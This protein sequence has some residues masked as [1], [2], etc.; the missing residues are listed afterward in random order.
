MPL[1]ELDGVSLFYETAGDGPPVLIVRGTGGDLRQA[2]G[3]FAWPGSD[4]F[5][6]LAYDHRDQGR[7]SSRDAEQPTMAEF[8]SDA[9]ALVDHVG[10]DRFSVVGISFGGMV[11]QELALAAG[12]RVRR[13]V[14]A[15]TSSGGAGSR[16]YPLH[17]LYA[18][19]PEERAARL[20]AL[21][22]TRTASQPELAAALA[23]YLANDRSLAA[24]DVPTAG[25]LRQL[26]ARRHHDT[27][28]RL[29]GLRLPTLVA[30][31][32]FD[33]IAPVAA[34]ERL[35][36]SIP[37][38]RLAVFGGGHGFLLQDPAAWPAIAGF[39]LLPL[40]SAVE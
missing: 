34:S 6:L 5:S 4:R 35:A 37:G 20:V 8:T 32:R 22:D 2:P 30:A 9:L 28:E 3:P 12:D 17:E 10:W 26:Q 15:C 1:A 27:S 40:A 38:A 19:A 36:E 24:H 29:G 7:S 31:G 18:L 25:L 13:L 14:L 23:L 16:S 33:G 21:L 11:A 39:L